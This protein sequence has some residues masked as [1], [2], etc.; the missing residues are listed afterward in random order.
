[1]G[2]GRAK[3]RG[4]VRPLDRRTFV[5]MTVGV[6]LSCAGAACASMVTHRVTPVGGVVRLSVADYPD[7][8]SPGGS[9]RIHPEGYTDP[10]YVLALGGGAYAA[11]SPICTHRGCTV[12]IEGED[13]VC[14]CHGSTYDRTG[15]VLVGPAERPL[16]SF[17]T[18]SDRDGSVIIRL[19]E[20]G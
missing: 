3:P 9:V 13:L 16:R 18:V 1:M 5:E 2:G 10:V 15:A 17:A 19:V 4:P 12:N 6:A 8:D 14:P 20:A 11:L 7:L